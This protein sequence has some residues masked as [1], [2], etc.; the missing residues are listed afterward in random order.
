M[1]SKSARAEIQNFQNTRKSAG[2]YYDEQQ[3][4]LGVGDVKTRADDLR[5]LIRNTETTLKGVNQSVAGRTRGQNVNEAQR[6]RL[7]G[8]ERA[9]LAEELSGHQGAY[10]DESQNYRDLLGQ[11]GTR[12]GLAYQ[13]DADKLAGLES[14]YGKLFAEEQ[15]AEERRRAEEE[16]R[17][18]WEEFNW[19]KQTSDRDFAE[20][21][22][23]ANAALARSASLTSNIPSFSAPSGGGGGSNSSIQKAQENA[24]K[25]AAEYKALQQS[26]W[27]S[28]P[29]QAVGTSKYN[30]VNIVKNDL[31]T[32]GIVSGLKRLF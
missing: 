14:I 25:A 9:P 27:W 4:E 20:S 15:A 32:K 12:A 2:N 26:N 31:R 29:V 6:A 1:D 24:A 28:A 10:A 8:L 7:E 13:S 21:R 3:K 22:R 18:F 30:P 11:A 16:T 17:R 5:G 23:Q 19:K